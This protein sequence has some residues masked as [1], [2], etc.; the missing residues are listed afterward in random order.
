MWMSSTIGVCRQTVLGLLIVAA[1]AAAT[2]GQDLADDMVGQT[3]ES[4]TLWRS[5]M[6]AVD[7]GDAARANELLT[8]VVD[9]D[10]SELRLALMA[11]R[12]G[13]VRL[14]QLAEGEDAGFGIKTVVAS[15][16]AGRR[17]KQLAE[18]G[19]HF[20]AIGRFKYADA[21][22]KALDESSPDP[23]A[24][25]ELSRRNPNRHLILVKLVASADVGPSAQRM[26]ELLDEGEERLRTDPYEIALNIEKLGGTPRRVF[27]ATQALVRSGEYAVPHLIQFLQDA[28][29]GEL[30]PAIVKVLPKLGRG[31][32]NPLCMALGMTDSV[33][34]QV[35]I[36]A[37]GQIGYRQALPYLA[38]LADN[39][40]EQD[41]VR[42]AAREAIRTIGASFD[43]NVSELFQE[44]AE[45]YY[46]N[47]ESLRADSRFDRANVW[48]L[49]KDQ[50]RFVPVPTRIFNDIMS[51]RCC[52]EAL[53]ADTANTDATALWLAA[54]FRREARLGLDV[55]NDEPDARADADATRPANYPRAIY[56]A[57][58]AGPMYN[59]RVLA[60]AVRDRDPGVALGA[61]AALSVTAG[62]PSLV[63]GEDVKQALVEALSF[64][65][66]QVRIKTALALAL[67]LPKTP[68]DQ[69][70]NVLPVLDEALSQSGR[71][72]ALIADPDDDSRN[73]FQALLRSAGFE[74][75]V[76]PTVFAA[77]SA[78]DDS[79]ISSFDVILIASDV[80][81]PDLVHAIGD[82]RKQFETA[83]TPIL[84]ISKG[85]DVS[86]VRN[87]DRAFAGTEILLAEVL[88]LG[89]P[90][91]MTKIVTD[92]FHRASRA[93]GMS[94][95]DEELSLD[96]ALRT[97]AALRGIA[98]NG[99]TIF[100]FKRA[101][102]AL[103]KALDNRSVELRISCAHSLALA[104]LPKAQASIAD[105]ALDAERPQTE[106]VKAFGSLAESARR[107][108]NLL[109]DDHVQQLIQL[110]MTEAN[111]VLRS[112]ASKALGALDLPTNRA[113][114]IIRNQSRG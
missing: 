92:K 61:I 85:G 108:G 96:L 33:T 13:S 28:K 109:G 106:R 84:I 8:Q 49:V 107:N 7:R 98:E 63:G 9:L 50:L 80:T 74:C 95:L 112:A 103:I 44:L 20:A 86:A 16:Q 72:T 19:W 46:R 3:R 88:D 111:L 99:D 23:V 55:E 36:T 29:Q 110:T 79:N 17:Q 24:L 26:I 58:A 52:E 5:A 1:S 67:A 38:E 42:S 65:N 56:F 47:D 76:G 37:L 57:R 15:I 87:A 51:M 70:Q 82:L 94:V 18:D 114:E 90:A 105:V 11:D 4:W 22:F 31:G 40:T 2:L 113:S 89:D 77:K 30:H 48:Y 45:A 39:E 78:A 41:D 10:L 73:R 66:R 60:R 100:D 59:H 54:N 27:R 91:R 93:L 35:L 14:E 53:G 32:L 34:K 75:A 21:N 69:S 43:H 25:L 64:P 102:D 97:A 62:E 83:A 81:E 104:A 71:L 12:S 101:V 6:D 68:F